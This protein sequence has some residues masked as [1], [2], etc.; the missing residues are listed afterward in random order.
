[1]VYSHALP[2]DEE[3]AEIWDSAFQKV[4]ADDL[5]RRSS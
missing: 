4:I 1:M 5:K 2:R 3:A